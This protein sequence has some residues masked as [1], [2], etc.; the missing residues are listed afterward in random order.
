[1]RGVDMSRYT[2]DFNR[3]LKAVAALESGGVTLEDWDRIA[4]DGDVLASVLSLLGHPVEENPLSA[5]SFS[6]QVRR[7][8]VDDALCMVS[9]LREY[10]RQVRVDPNSFLDDEPFQRLLDVLRPHQRRIV[11]GYYLNGSGLYPPAYDVVARAARM[12]ESTVRNYLGGTKRAIGFEMRQMAESSVA[13]TPA[14]RR[15]ETD[16]EETVRRISSVRP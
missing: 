8:V 14:S 10:L 1:M 3:V 15:W 16:A 4:N 5:V 2:R 13:A 11:E 6:R 12:R 9:T 7:L